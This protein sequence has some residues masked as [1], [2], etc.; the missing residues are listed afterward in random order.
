MFFSDKQNEY[1]LKATHRWN[2]KTGATRSGKTYMDYYMIPRRIRACQGEG[3]IVILGNTQATIE[4]NILEPMRKIYGPMVGSV[5]QNNEVYLFGQKCYAI[6][7]DKK[8][9]VARIQGAGFEYCYGD[10]ITTWSEDVFQ[11]LKSRLSC[12]HSIFDGTCNPAGSG[13]WF[14]KFLD[15]G[16]D[17]YNQTYTIDD[18]PFLDAEMVAN[19]K[20]EYQG[21]I[22]YDR[23]ILGHWVAAE[24]LIYRRFAEHPEAFI[25]DKVPALLEAIIGVDF[26]GGVSGH[27]FC[28]VGFTPGYQQ[29]VILSDYWCKDAL[30][31]TRLNQEFL[32]FAE[33]NSKYPIFDCWCDSEETTL[34]NGM[35]RAVNEKGWPLHVGK[36]V[37]RPINDRIRAMTSLMGSG[38]VKVMANCIYTIDA[39]KTAVWANKAVDD[40]RLDDGTTNIDSLD[41]MEYAYERRLQNLGFRG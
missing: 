30:D 26:G 35:A 12:K 8:G 34:I 23:Y 11:M 21:T 29:M 28:C 6:G 2:I 5:R 25:I 13:H 33:A 38:R 14:K 19:L 36:C 27:A 4:R 16:A 15:S 1:W 3:L 31:P 10:E 9:Q 24:G 22:Y 18:N 41:A 7:A 37:K 32:S 40:V 17:I 39:L 20:S